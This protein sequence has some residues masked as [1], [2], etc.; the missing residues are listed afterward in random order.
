MIS[1][2]PLAKANDKAN[3]SSKDTKQNCHID[4]QAIIF[5]HCFQSSILFRIKTA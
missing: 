4:E 1:I 5:H 2:V 3:L